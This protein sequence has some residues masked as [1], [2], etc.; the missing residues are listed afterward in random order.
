[1]LSA[2]RLHE[3]GVVPAS[4]RYINDPKYWRGRAEEARGMAKGSVDPDVVAMMINVARQYEQL[5]EQAEA[6]LKTLPGSR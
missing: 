1:M 2:S 3:V 5:A 6:R 4:S